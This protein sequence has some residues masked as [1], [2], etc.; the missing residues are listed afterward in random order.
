MR[1]LV[2]GICAAML[3]RFRL[4]WWI[5]RIYNDSFLRLIVR[6][7]VG[8]IVPRPLPCRTLGFVLECSCRCSY[9][10]ELIG[11]A[12]RELLT[13]VWLAAQVRTLYTLFVDGKSYFC[14]WVKI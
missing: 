10:S 7:Q 6:N 9:T 1:W 11:Y 14:D 8:V 4:L 5:R 3:H 12:L 13:R 2:I